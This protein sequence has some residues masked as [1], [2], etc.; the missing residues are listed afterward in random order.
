MDVIPGRINQFEITPTKTGH[1]AGRC[2]ELCGTYHSQM[3]FYVDVVSPA[4]YQTYIE[5]LRATGH[6]GQ[7]DTGRANDDAQNQ[8]RT[9]IGG[10]VDG[11]VTPG[12]SQ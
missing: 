10:S 4:D 1:F 8:G 12:G 11:Y 9:E 7:L 3:L 6:K 2:A 5:G